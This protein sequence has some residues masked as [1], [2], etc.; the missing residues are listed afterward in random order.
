MIRIRFDGRS[1]DRF[2]SARLAGL[3]WVVWTI[4]LLGQCGV[5][6]C[7]FGTVFK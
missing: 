3:P 5:V 7:G 4:I 6:T 2:L 1:A